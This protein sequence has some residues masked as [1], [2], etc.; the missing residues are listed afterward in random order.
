ME[1]KVS[2]GSVF[3]SFTAPDRRSQRL[4]WYPAVFLTFSEICTSPG[5]FPGGHHSL[6]NV[7]ENVIV[8][9]IRRTDST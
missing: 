1:T 7:I 8:N 4:T 5:Y 9:L 3:Y 2:R 6:K